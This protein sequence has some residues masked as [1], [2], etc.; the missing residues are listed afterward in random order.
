MDPRDLVMKTE[1]GREQVSQRAQSLPPK[2][3]RL[4]IMLD[5]TRSVSELEQLFAPL[6]NVQEM[7]KDLLGRGLISLRSLRPPPAAPGPA[8]TAAPT[9]P[10][11]SPPGMAPDATWPAGAAIEGDSLAALA[12]TRPEPM[13]RPAPAMRPP[14]PRMPAPLAPPAPMAAA[15]DLGYAAA[16]ERYQRTA[17]PYPRPASP[18]DLG[19]APQR[20]RVA[21]FPSGAPVSPE[22]V[23]A[24]AAPAPDFELVQ[25]KAQIRAHLTGVL[26]SDEALIDAKLEA[27]S[28]RTQLRTFLAG[29][30]KV[31]ATYGGIRLS[32]KFRERFGQY[33]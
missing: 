20:S 29:C 24:A 10:L 9:G 2:L 15:A 28:D 30:E 32:N 3:R 23:L 19:A 11:P 4:L 31:L 6:G 21:A 26:G 17:A 7:L 22:A 16:M 1:Q 27:V 8:A 13:P 33:Y 18:T 25:L 14:E 5:G 12:P